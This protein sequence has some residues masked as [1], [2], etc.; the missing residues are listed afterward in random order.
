LTECDRED[1]Q[2]EDLGDP[3]APAGEKTPEIVECR[4][5]VGKGATHTGNEGTALGEDECNQGR[6]YSR[7]QPDHQGKRAE[8]PCRDC[9]R[10]IDVGTH[11]RPDDDARDIEESEESPGCHRLSLSCI[12]R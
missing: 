3:E 5:D 9:R 2:C 7:D 8:E 10:D 11:D 12:G 1:R 6:E 4:G